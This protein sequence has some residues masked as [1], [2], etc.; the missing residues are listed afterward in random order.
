MKLPVRCIVLSILMLGMPFLIRAQSATGNSADREQILQL[1]RDWTQSF[2]AMDVAA[3]QRIV[4]DDFLGT[5]TDGKRV[6][7]ADIIAEV[8][9]GEALVSNRLNEDDVTIRFYGQTA[10]VNGSES[11]KRKDGKTGR[12][13][14][15]DVF[16]KRSGK[17]QVVASQDF[18]VMDK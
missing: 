10:V 9:T 18:E 8:K 5:E 3:N 6:K 16:V 14:W 11:W 7:K 17:W 13:V 1:E 15:T 2:V 12:W 4:A